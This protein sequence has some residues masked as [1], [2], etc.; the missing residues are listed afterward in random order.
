MEPRLPDYAPQY[1]AELDKHLKALTKKHEDELKSYAENSLYPPKDGV[2]WSEKYK[3]LVKR[4]HDELKE[5]HAKQ[6]EYQRVKDLIAGKVPEKTKDEIKQEKIDTRFKAVREEYLKKGK[7]EIGDHDH[8]F[9]M[10]YLHRVKQYEK[11]GNGWYRS[12]LLEDY[13]YSEQQIDQGV[14]KI[15]SIEHREAIEKLTARHQTRQA[16]IVIKRDE[17]RVIDPKKA[18]DE[19]VKRTA[20]LQHDS[21]KDITQSVEARLKEIEREKAIREMQEKLQKI[22][23]NSK[24]LG[25]SL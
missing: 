17:D 6:A 16:D 9:E 20:V 2:P 8:L 10:H 5:H 22:R 4:Q 14:E 3:R 18:D 12:V 25:R 23:E 21:A 7:P 24:D 1:Q 13:N 15:R 19:F 11:T